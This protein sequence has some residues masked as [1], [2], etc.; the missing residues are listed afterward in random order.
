MKLINERTRHVV[1]GRVALAVTRQDRRRG[2]LGRDSLDADEAMFISPCFSVHTVSMRFPIDVVFIDGDGRAV[3]MVHALRPWR[4]AASFRGR[5][6]IELAAGRL[7]ESG[8]Q[9]GD[10]LRLAAD[11]C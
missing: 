1:A 3:Q 5:S 7:K 2:L 8:V 6:V 4:I 10:R 9:L 11:P